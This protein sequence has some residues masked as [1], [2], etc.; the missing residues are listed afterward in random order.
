MMKKENDLTKDFKTYKVKK[1]NTDFQEVK[2]MIRDTQNPFD[3]NIDQEY[4]FNL[5]TGKAASKETETF[6]LNMESVREEE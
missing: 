3:N 2:T 6:L 5:G 1:D 4:F